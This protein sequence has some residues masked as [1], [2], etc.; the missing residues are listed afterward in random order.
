MTINKLATQILR[1]NR[2]LL[3]A[4]AEALMSASILTGPPFEAF[5]RRVTNLATP[6]CRE[7]T[8]AD[9]QASKPDPEAGIELTKGPCDL[10]PGR[11]SFITRVLG[12]DS[13]HFGLGQA[14]RARSPQIAQALGALQRVFCCPAMSVA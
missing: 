7:E 13:C 12:V 5:L 6:E 10:P 11:P 3:N 9:P 8:C 1:I 14:R 4:M 2:A